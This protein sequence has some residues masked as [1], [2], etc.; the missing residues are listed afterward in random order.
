MLTPIR[1]DSLLRRD[2]SALQG[3]EGQNHND[4]GVI[5]SQDPSVL[6]SANTSCILAPE[7]TIGPYYV[8]GEYVRSKLTESQKGIPMHLEMQ[9][10]NVKTCK[11]VQDLLVDIWHVN[12]TGTYSGI[13]SEAGLN[14]TWLRG[15]QQSS[16][17]GV[18]EFDTNFP[19]HYS[20]R[21]VHTHL[22]VQTNATVLA[23]GSYTGGT[24]SHVGQLFYSEALI[25]AVEATSPYSLNT[26]KRTTNDEDSIAQS[27]ADNNFDPL[28]QFVYLNPSNIADGVLAWIQVGIDP[29]ANHTSSA[30]A[31]AYLA[32][33]GGHAL[34]NGM[35][36]GEPGGMG[37][38]PGNGTK[39]GN[40]TTSSGAAVATT[41]SSGANS[42]VRSP[43][44][45]LGRYFGF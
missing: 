35:G 37:G 21:A 42:L 20:G 2:L 39:G 27:Q 45:L 11:P 36:S 38:P 31:A 33:D 19:G 1:T 41:S 14:T 26:V 44:G 24:F 13:A 6:F 30:S 28:V 40:T 4:T 18:V 43:F 16:S 25:N 7:V 8:L 29:S 34:S 5:A 17:S 3:F 32:A 12:S 23:N 10:I 9:F 22:A 15:V